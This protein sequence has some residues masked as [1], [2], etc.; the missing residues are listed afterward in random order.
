MI[1]ATSSMEKSLQM[2]TKYFIDICD[3]WKIKIPGVAFKFGGIVY[4]DPIDYISDR[5]YYINLTDNKIY[6]K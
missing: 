3:N 2:A 6:Y 1:D 4:R 5:I